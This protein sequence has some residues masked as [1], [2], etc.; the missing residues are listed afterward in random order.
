[1]TDYQIQPHTRRC[2]LTG[3]ALQPG[4]KFYTA[5]VEEG[6][7]F[8]RKDYAGDAWQGPPPGA[9]GYWCGKVPAHDG[10]KLQR[11]DDE[12]LIDCFTR[13]EGDADPSR[14][15]FR[16]VVALLL[17]RRKRFKFE[18]SHQQDDLEILRLRCAQTGACHEVINPRL[19]EDKMAAAE[20]EVFQVLGWSS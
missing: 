4:E 7:Q 9:F 8:V 3:R 17:L 10:A 18:A 15:N 5:L 2:A 19:T 13:L 14:V 6:A 20:H 12:M 11:C 1:M 16:Y